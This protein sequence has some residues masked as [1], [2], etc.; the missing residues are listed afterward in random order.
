M[1]GEEGFVTR[2]RTISDE[3]VISD[4]WFDAEGNP[5]SPNEDTY[6][7]ADYTYDKKGNINRVK[8]YDLEGY[9]VCCL[10]GYA[11]VYRE[12][13]AFNRVD[14]EKFFGT[15]GFAIRLP[16]GAVSYRYQY[17][18]EGNILKQSKYDFA[19]HEIEE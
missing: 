12:F 10:A 11:I 8:Y 5:M 18:D 1:A 3:K 14:Y 19:D 9:P 17:D 2:V 16:D 6:F 7:R 4:R 15:D 13:D